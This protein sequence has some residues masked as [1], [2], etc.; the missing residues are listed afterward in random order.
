MS[1]VS[2]LVQSRDGDCHIPEATAATLQI[3]PVNFEGDLSPAL[4]NGDCG[5]KV[6]LGS[7]RINLRFLDCEERPSMWSAW[8]PLSKGQ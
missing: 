5:E 3:R 4:I 7:R 6:V 2:E 1:P 8:H